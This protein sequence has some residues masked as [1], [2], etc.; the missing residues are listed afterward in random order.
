MDVCRELTDQLNW[1]W[2]NHARPRLNGLTDEEYFWEPVP[3][4]WSVR[5]RGT[6][7]A[8]LQV[9]RGDYTIDFALPEPVPAPVTTIA[10]RIGHML[11]GVLGERLA[12]HFGGEPVTYRDFV[13]PESA[14]QALEK[15]DAAYSSWHSAVSALSLEEMDRPVGPAEGPFAEAPMGA[16]VQH[17]NREMIH[18]LAEVALLRDLW[19]HRAADGLTGAVQS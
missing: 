1:H 5:P 18:H 8:P 2:E 12:S 4:C 10:W 13:Y 6:G 3:G 7:T 17:I 9:G 16:L 15:L 11:V 14:E 19:A